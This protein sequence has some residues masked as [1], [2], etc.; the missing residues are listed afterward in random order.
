MFDIMSGERPPRPTHNNL[1]NE[2]W[3]LVQK[4]WNQD[5]HLRPTVSEVLN[6]LRGM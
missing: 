1:T 6:T 4:C 2:L 3:A 5:P